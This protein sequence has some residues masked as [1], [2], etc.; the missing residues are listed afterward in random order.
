ML[1]FQLWL[2]RLEKQDRMNMFYLLEQQAKDPQTTTRPF[3]ITP[4]DAAAG[5]PQ[6]E[7]TYGEAYQKVLKWAAWLQNEHGVVK[8]EIVVMDYMNRPQFM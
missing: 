1:R 3:V 8:G 4:G 6:T 7:T 2:K 5:V